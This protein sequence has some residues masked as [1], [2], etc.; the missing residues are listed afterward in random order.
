[1]LIPTQRAA[2]TTDRRATTRYAARGTEA[3][4]VWSDGDQ[5]QTTSAR[6]IDVSLGGCFANVTVLP[7]EEGRVWLQLVGLPSSAPIEARVVAA[8]QRGRFVWTRR[9]LRLEF[10]EGCPYDVFKA[11]IEGF[12]REVR[13]PDFEAKGFTTRDWR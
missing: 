12:S 7:P 4:V 5:Q 8:I 6:L 13:L 3:L 11:A 2:A 10:V 9:L 1:L